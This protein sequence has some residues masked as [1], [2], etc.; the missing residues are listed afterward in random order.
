MLKSE[1]SFFDV[2][3]AVFTSCCSVASLPSDWLSVSANAAEGI[4]AITST[5]D[6]IID[7]NLLLLTFVSMKNSCLSMISILLLF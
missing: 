4:S 6:K 1:V 2:V 3:S 7:K 5:I